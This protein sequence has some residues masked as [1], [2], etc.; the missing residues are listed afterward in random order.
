MLLPFIVSL[1]V[2]ISMENYNAQR[3]HA[4]R[5][6][7]GK[8]PKPSTAEKL[9]KKWGVCPLVLLLTACC[10]NTADSPVI[11]KGK[12]IYMTRCQIEQTCPADDRLLTDILEN[13]ELLK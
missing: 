5:L 9:F 6:L 4:M 12:V 8:T 1:W 2:C 3:T 7:K 10:Q 11:R 13:N